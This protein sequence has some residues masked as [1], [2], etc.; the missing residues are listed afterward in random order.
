[1][2]K[3]IFYVFFIAVLGIITVIGTKIL[4]SEKN[5]QYIEKIFR[6]DIKVQNKLGEIRNYRIRKVGKFYGNPPYQQGYDYYTLKVNGGKSSAFIYL[7]LYKNN[8]GEI[9]S[10]KVEIDE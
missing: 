9:E 4:H 8:N 1:M 7:K 3:L 10:Y 2:K 5:Q 6:E